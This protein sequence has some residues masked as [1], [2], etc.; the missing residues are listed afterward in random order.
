MQFQLFDG[1]NLVASMPVMQWPL[2]LQINDSL[3]RLNKDKSI[4]YNGKATNTVPIGSSNVCMFSGSGGPNVAI[5]S[6]EVA[7]VRISGYQTTV[8]DGHANFTLQN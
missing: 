6:R 8:F 7:K 1:D 3:Y 2:V 5:G 4:T